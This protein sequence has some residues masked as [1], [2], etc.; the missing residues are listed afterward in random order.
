MVIQHFIFKNTIIFLVE[1]NTLYDSYDCL[2]LLTLTLG[3][4]PECHFTDE[5]TEV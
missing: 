2:I 3:G 5:E 1:N 4:W